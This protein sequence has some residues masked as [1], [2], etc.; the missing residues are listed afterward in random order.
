MKI[1]VVTA[2]YN[3]VQTV[4]QAIQSVSQQ[5]AN[6]IE[7]I[8][9]D[10]MSDDG[11]ADIIEQ[12]SHVITK[13]I[14]EKDRGIYDALNKGITAAS[15]DVVGFL[16]ADDL[17]ASQNSLNSIANVFSN[18]NVDAVYA[19]L[20]YVGFD[21]PNQI[22]RYWNSGEYNMSS[23]RWG[24]M[25]PHP[26]VYVKREVYEKYGA[27]R[28]DLGSGADYECMVRLMVKHRIRVAYLP[29]IV[30]KMRGRW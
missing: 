17:L 3:R 2:V 14:R 22:V 23:F 13:S 19:N 25:P 30:V 28:T 16:H 9:V 7:F 8:T 15:G 21:D 20:L 6:D 4:E 29:E 27:Y 5:I 11:T 24:W 12:N 18:Q 26:T 1:S 10:G